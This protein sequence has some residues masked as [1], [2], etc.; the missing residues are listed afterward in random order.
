MNNFPAFIN[1]PLI[2]SFE[3]SLVGFSKNFKDKRQRS[4]FFLLMNSILHQGTPLFSLA[5]RLTLKEKKW[6]RALSGFI[7]SSSWD[8]TLIDAMRYSLIGRKLRSSLKFIVLDF[9]ALVKRGSSFENQGK[10]Y[11]GRDGKIK[12]GFPYLLA[13]G[14]DRKASYK[15]TLSDR[16]IS[17]NKDIS[18]SKSANRLIIEFLKD[19]HSTLEIKIGLNK[20]KT[21]DLIHLGDREFDRKPIVKWWLENSY[22]FIVQAKNKKVKLED[23]RKILISEL[24]KGIYPDT[25]IICWGLHLNLVVYKELDETKTA[26]LTNLNGSDLKKRD[27]TFDDIPSLFD[28]RWKVDELIE[29]LKQNYGLE[30]FRVRKWQAIEKILSLILLAQTLNQIILKSQEQLAETFKQIIIPQFNYLNTL[31]VRFLREIALKVS[32]FGLASCFPLNHA[33][34]RANSP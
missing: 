11:D 28:Y 4:N 13:A 24:E 23:G 6:P 10:V 32:Y 31:S 3:K 33:V 30:K 25:E 26:L 15:C 27:L 21:Q 8:K 14:L 1:L 7:N 22:K 9:T 34:L 18:K 20:G 2:R 12:D 17:W 29:E 16:L 5:Q 19:L